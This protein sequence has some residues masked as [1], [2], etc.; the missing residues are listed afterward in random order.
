MS[1]NTADLVHERDREGEYARNTAAV[2]PGGLSVIGGGLVSSGGAAVDLNPTF[3]F[4]GGWG[5]DENNASG[6]DA[7]IT[8]YA[9][10]AS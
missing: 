9:L 1:A 4:T 6:S 2:G 3:P 5:G 8:A 10:C 7:N